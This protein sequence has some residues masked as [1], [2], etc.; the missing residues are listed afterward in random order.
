MA[1]TVILEGADAGAAAKSEHFSDHWDRW[2]C[3]IPLKVLHTEYASVVQPDRRLHRRAARRPPRRS[4]GRPD[5]HC[6]TLESCATGS[7]TTRST[8]PSRPRCDAG[9][10][11]VVARV[12]VPLERPRPQP[13]AEAEAKAGQEPASGPRP[14]TDTT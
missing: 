3:G 10:D 7:S 6:A 14:G 13:E 9:T 1:V 8:W 11:V 2:N 12:T 5:P 4:T